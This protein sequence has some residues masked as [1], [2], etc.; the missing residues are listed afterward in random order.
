MEKCLIHSVDISQ[1]PVVC[2]VPGQVPAAIFVDGWCVGHFRDVISQKTHTRT[3]LKAD[4]TV[5]P[6]YRGGS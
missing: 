5:S 1:V 2:D 3:R 4:T 6:F